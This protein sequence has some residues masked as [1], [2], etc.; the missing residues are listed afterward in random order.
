M[1]LA[2]VPQGVCSAQPKHC[3][4]KDVFSLVGGDPSCCRVSSC[5]V[6]ALC[7][8]FASQFTWSRWFRWHF[9]GGSFC[10]PL[11]W[12][13]TPWGE[14]AEIDYHHHVK[15]LPH[16]SRNSCFQ[17]SFLQSSSFLQVPHSPT[18]VVSRDCG[19]F[20]LPAVSLNRYIN[21]SWI[22]F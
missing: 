5:R 3:G 17:G 12:I 16:T 21:P 1:F 15:N 6:R 2:L 18:S 22:T 7:L 14:E 19:D 20:F 11:F 8:Q 10:V 13:S 9:K 4:V